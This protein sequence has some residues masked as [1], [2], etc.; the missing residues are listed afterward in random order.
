MEHRAQAQRAWVDWMI[1]LD[2]NFDL[3]CCWHASQYLRI[4]QWGWDEQ[5]LKRHLSAY[6]NKVSK[7]VFSNVPVKQ[8]SN[9][10]RFITLEHADGVGWHAH[11]VLSKPKHVTEEEFIEIM[12]SLWI[13]Q[14]GGYRVGRLR[15]RLFDCKQ[16]EGNYQ[17]YALK[18]A[19]DKDEHLNRVLRGT[20]DEHNTRRP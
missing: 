9:I 19:T 6:F 2:A 17:Q 3:A 1:G 10:A 13:D 16:I 15:D 7:R 14:M 20:W 4:E 5:W 18:S 11:G 8:R 12:R